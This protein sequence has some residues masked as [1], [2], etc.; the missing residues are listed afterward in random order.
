MLIEYYSPDWWFI[1]SNFI[2]ILGVSTIVTVFSYHEFFCSKSKTNLKKALTKNSFKKYIFWGLI[3]VSS[4]FLLS[5]S[6]N[7]NAL[8]KSKFMLIDHNIYNPNKINRLAMKKLLNIANHEME[9]KITD[10]SVTEKRYL[11]FKEFI[12]MPWN[13][14]IGTP[15]INFDNGL[16]EFEF[17]GYGSKAKNEYSKIFVYFVFLRNK[18]LVLEKLLNN[19]EL[20]GA[21]HHY[22][23]DFEATRNLTGKIL[24]QF[25]N[26]GGDEKGGDRNVWIG[27]FRIRRVNS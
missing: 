23:L 8:R 13:G 25:F 10:T 1:I 15:F 26:D 19:I 21:K 9:M 4:G 27:S 22:C 17:E 11:L 20:A 6:N 14:Y 3:L 7:D 5:L 16:Y 12:F 24:I 18:R 2:W